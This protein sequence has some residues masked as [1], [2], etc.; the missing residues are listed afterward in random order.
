MKE[1]KIV[2]IG[3]LIVISQ[4]IFITINIPSDGWSRGYIEGILGATGLILI[5]FSKKL[6]G[7]KHE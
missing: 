4:F 3:F 2:I 5:L 7:E 6:V 1:N